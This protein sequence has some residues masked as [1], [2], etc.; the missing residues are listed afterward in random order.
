M[1]TRIIIYSGKG[2]TGKTT[3]SA[4]TAALIASRGQRVLIMSSDPAHSL[5]DV[6]GQPI[7]RD[8]L[9]LLAPNLYGLEIDTIHEMRKRVSGYQQFIANSYETQGIG[10]SVA[11]ELANQPGMDEILALNRLREEYESQKWDCIVVDTAPT[12]NTLRLLAYPDMIIGGSSGKN[13]FKV[14]RGFSNVVRPFRQQTPGDDFFK[15]V[16]NLLDVM[17]ALSSFIISDDVSVRLVLNPEK[18]PLMETKRAYTFLSL[19]GIRLDAI[20]INKIL[21]RK[22]QLGQYFDYWVKL[23][24]RY[25][26]QIEESFAPMPIFR[27]QLEDEE[28]IG[29]ER[30]RP[31]AERLFGEADPMG[32]LYDRKLLWVEN[33]PSTPTYKNGPAPLARREFCVYLPFVDVQD[34]IDITRNGSDIT[35]SAGRVQRVVS[36]P[37]ILV[38]SEL[39]KFYYDKDVLRMEFAEQPK[40]EI[41]WEDDPFFVASNVN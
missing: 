16:N 12:G 11:A 5:S 9:T 26:Q 6:L 33:L 36:L 23:Q 34:E 30:L 13:F 37:R 25:L 31:V 10:T 29:V 14:Y 20:V 7:S 3:I 19:Y 27:S 8:S 4:A 40:E 17:K 35:V 41:V 15:E 22:K 18:L 28:P 32:Q 1:S 39:G 21:P 24:E 38:D 2:G